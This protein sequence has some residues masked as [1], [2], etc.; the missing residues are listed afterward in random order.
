MYLPAGHPHSSTAR[1]TLVVVALGRTERLVRCLRSLVEH[2][3]SVPFSIVC[4]INPLHGTAG[5][6]DER[7]VQGIEATGARVMAPR[8]NLGWAGGL[9]EGRRAIG[10]E[11]FAWVQDDM[12]VLPG[13]LDALVGAADDDPR[14]GALGS[15]RV[16]RDGVVQLFNGGWTVPDDLAQWSSTDTSQQQRP[17]GVHRLDW[18]TSRGLLVRTRAWDEVGGADP[19]LFPLTYVDLD[20]CT[21]LRAHGWGVALVG[22]AT[23]W[24]AHNQSASGLMREYLNERLT[25]RVNERWAAVTAALPHGAA[26]EHPHD[27]TRDR[28]D[29]VEGWVA[30]EAT[31][32]VVRFG[33]WAEQTRRAETDALRAQLTEAELS[34]YQSS[35]E[36]AA[37]RASR[38]WRL[39]APLRA[40]RHRRGSPP[41]T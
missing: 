41:G 24:H 26:A 28:A 13:W 7:A 12:E 8:M 31:D 16:E 40:L 10:T 14:V 38:S 17:V 27:C 4:V 39:T 33:R 1:V 25:P 6:V 23:V 20:F 15:V 5:E 19:S 11:F 2:E 21:H 37:V 18:V 3:T 30:R 9:H 32:I 29:D 22:E 34:A 35:A 36:L